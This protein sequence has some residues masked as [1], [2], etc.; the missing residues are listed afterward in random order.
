MDDMHFTV[1]YA[2]GKGTDRN[3]N[4]MVLLAEWEN[5]A[6]IFSGDIGKEQE[7]KLVKDKCFQKYLKKSVTFYKAAHHGSDNSNSLEVL[8]ELSP[9]LAVVSCG[10]GNPYGHPGKRAVERMEQAGAQICYT[11]NSGQIRLWQE[12][13]SV[14]LWKFQN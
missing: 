7:Q 14:L 8:E 5:I 1:L 13:G 3:Q 4:S 2:E 9:K 11:M 6:G 12:E 10:K